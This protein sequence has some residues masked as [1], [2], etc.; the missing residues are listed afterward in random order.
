MKDV[1]CRSSVPS[2]NNT[3]GTHVTCLL[4]KTQVSAKD[5][6]VGDVVVQGHATWMIAEIRPEPRARIAVLDADG[7]GA[8]C[9][10]TSLFWILSRDILAYEPGKVVLE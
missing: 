6:L 1:I 4:P 8:V 9:D 2:H 5:L 3:R 10:Q 7:N